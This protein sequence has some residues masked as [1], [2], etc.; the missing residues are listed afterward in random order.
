M[1][2]ALVTGGAGFLGSAVVRL[3]REQGVR[4][5]VLALPNEQLDNLEG[6]DFELLRGNVMSTRDTLAAA[7]GVD[8]L[9]HCA[10]IY[11]D[12]VADPTAMYQVNLRGT[13]NML[14]AAR[15]TGVRKVVYTASVV[16]LGRPKPGEL[17]N[18]DTP[19]EAWDLNFHYSRSKHLSM[20][21]AL[22][23]AN[24]GLD[25]SVVCPAIV[26][27]PGD[28]TPTPSGQLIV[29]ICRGQAYGYTEGG[30]CYVDVR[31]AAQVHVLAALHGKPGNRYV[32]AGH[33]LTHQQFMAVVHQAYDR[34]LPTPHKV[35]TTL[36]RAA[37]RGMELVTRKAGRE[38]PMTTEY[39]SYG[40]KPGY[41]SSDKAKREL[42]A[43]FRPIDETVRD[44]IAYFR[45]QGL[46]K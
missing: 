43:T 26:F 6:L 35:P 28:I 25:L 33:N 42:G 23:F 27:G 24:W 5:R 11:K 12:Y 7:D 46:I 31:D 36:A 9:F 4:V 2:L 38:P 19:Y 29:Q 8:T 14:E 3:L 15:R 44:A 34:K 18:E 16:A 20:L 17:A 32:A 40:L 1:N 41:F 10:A 30:F 21:T 13:F 45:A 37:V 39:M 22:D